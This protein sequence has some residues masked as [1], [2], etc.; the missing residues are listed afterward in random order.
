[1]R[2]RAKGFQ[3]ALTT[4]LLRQMSLAERQTSVTS[5]DDKDFDK[6]GAFALLPVSVEK[7]FI[8]IDS[9][10][11]CLQASFPWGF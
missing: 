10:Y 2:D 9:R 1:M 3:L 11:Q 4:R 5:Q 7:I 8:F 6:W